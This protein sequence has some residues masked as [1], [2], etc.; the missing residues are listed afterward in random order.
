MRI[1]IIFGTA[2]QGVGYG[3]AQALLSMQNRRTDV[4][5]R[6]EIVCVDLFP[7]LASKDP[8]PFPLHHLECNIADMDQVSNLPT[9][10]RQLLNID[11]L[12]IA[13]IINCVAVFANSGDILSA[14]PANFDLAFRVNVLGA[15]YIQSTFL[16]ILILNPSPSQIIHCS[17]LASLTH[18]AGEPY[19]SSKIAL[20]S[21]VESTA[22]SLQSN[23][24]TRHVSAH[25]ILPGVVNTKFAESSARVKKVLQP[26]PNNN[27]NK[28]SNHNSHNKGSA[29]AGSDNENKVF[30]EMMS[31]GHSPLELANRA[32]DQLLLKPGNSGPKP[33][34][35]VLDNNPPVNLEQDQSLRISTL[36]HGGIPAV[37]TPP[38]VF[39]ARRRARL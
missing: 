24:Q 32:L 33:F 4:F 34:L 28:P 36:L 11:H 31:L 6:L 19:L 16:P 12:D 23:P 27:N 25:L 14:S 18:G 39:E 38:I 15:V 1:A 17:S 2:N 5:E 3:F 9:R 7:P 13:L 20:N 22:R 35:V 30:K 29:F 10:I 26:R 8:Q 37:N 21:I